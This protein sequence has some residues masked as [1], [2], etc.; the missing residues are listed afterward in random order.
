MD[1]KQRTMLALGL[2][3]VILIA[4]FALFDKVK[5]GK[6]TPG[7]AQQKTEVA[8]KSEEVQTAKPMDV[9]PTAGISP[10]NAEDRTIVVDTPLYTAAFSTR[11]ARITSFKLKKYLTTMGKD[12]QPVEVLKT[13]LPTLILKGGSSDADL[14]YVSDRKGSISVGNTLEV[15]E[16]RT[17]ASPG[18]TLRKVFTIDPGTYELGYQTVI[19]NHTS[20]PMS[21]SGEILF[22]NVYPL[23]EKTK[24]YAFQGPV[25]LNGKHLE[26]FK[27]D[28]VKKVGSYR[29]FTGEV[30]WFGFEDKYF[31]QTIISKTPSN[32][33]LTIK[34]VDDKVVELHYALTPVTIKAGASFTRD[35]L[36]FIGPKEL[37][38]LKAAGYNLSKALDFGFFDII[39]KP[40]LLSMNWIYRYAGSYGWTIIILTVIIKI[41]LYPLTLKS[42]TSMKELQKIQ[43]LM[44]EIQQQ[45]K[46]DKQK[47]NQELMRLYQEHKINPMGG[48]LPMV[49]QIPILFALYKVFYQAIE[50]RH[51][52][53]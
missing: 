17:E 8:T 16:F 5:I 6:E 39:A 21:A 22:D 11:G 42:F 37:K 14:T 13:P 34:R 41:L 49:L 48:C 51:T 12:A 23:D 28:K 18:I 32:T 27:V 20:A 7:P 29:E 50:L 10:A 52:P 25:L 31:L 53:F 36:I 1:E 9:S 4:W 19:E 38:T 24:G 47:M 35:S 3:A 40:L 45:Y 30:Q 33:T 43:P 46:D 44:K 15:V 2:T 26:E